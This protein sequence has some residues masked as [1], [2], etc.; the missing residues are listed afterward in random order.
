M[1]SEIK[2]KWLNLLR[3]NKY[4][5]GKRFLRTNDDKYCCLG[6]LCDL[7]AKEHNVSWEKDTYGV[8]DI[9]FHT[10]LGQQSFLPNAVRI[11]AGLQDNIPL[12][13]KGNLAGLN[14]TGRSFS[15]IADIIEE[16]L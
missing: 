11:W 8:S 7:Y 15:E 12:T 2:E 4:A 1:N 3:S 13:T 6:V 10:F 14:D 5:Q 9:P 16:Y